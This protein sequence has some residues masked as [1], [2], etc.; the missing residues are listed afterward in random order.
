MFKPPLQLL[1]TRPILKCIINCL[2]C[3]GIKCLKRNQYF[4]IIEAINT[5]TTFRQWCLSMAQHCQLKVH[6]VTSIL[7]NSVMSNL[8]GKWKTKVA[9]FLVQGLAIVLS[10]SCPN[11]KSQS[12]FFGFQVPSEICKW[13]VQ[14]IQ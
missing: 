1:S 10:A 6:M 13:S 2:S 12:G 5:I 11:L 14:N 3:A 7:I 8:N 9:H 4:P